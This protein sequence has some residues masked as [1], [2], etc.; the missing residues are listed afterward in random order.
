MKFLT[1]W[2]LLPQKFNDSYVLGTCYIPS[3]VFGAED[4][5]LSK[6]ES[7]ASRSGW[8]RVWTGCQAGT[9]SA[10]T[11]GEGRLRGSCWEA[12]AFIIWVERAMANWRVDTMFRGGSWKSAPVNLCYLCR[13]SYQI[14]W[15]FRKLV[16]F[17]RN[18]KIISCQYNFL[19]TF[20]KHVLCP[21]LYSLFLT[22]SGFSNHDV[23]CLSRE[24]SS[25]LIRIG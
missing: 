6:A 20:I 2:K 5:K 14:F 13:W 22:N 18:Y 21:L 4:T 1:L 23:W 8:L 17:M 10:M 15:G 16:Y 3:T 24:V 19:K 12:F 25:L 11:D 9:K 7:L